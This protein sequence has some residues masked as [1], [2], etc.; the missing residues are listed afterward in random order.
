MSNP[1]S[2][3]SQNQKPRA[4]AQILALMGEDNASLRADRDKWRE[5]CRAWQL[6]CLGVVIIAGLLAT[7]VFKPE[8]KYFGQVSDG[9]NS[10]IVPLRALDK[11]IVT[12]GQVATFAADASA[13]ALSFSFANWERELKY[14]DGDYMP[15]AAAELRTALNATQFFDR[16]EQTASVTTAAATQTP[17]IV[18]EQ[19]DPK[20]GYGWKLEFP[21]TVTWHGRSTRTE[22]RKVTVVVRQVDPLI[23]PRGIQVERINIG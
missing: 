8:A 19:A 12:P 5:S 21:M 11:P 23:N 14:L 17:V 16:L 13:K 6:T 20:L 10:F 4:A 15:S 22:T 7:D 9:K 3:V 2:K 1:V 18:A